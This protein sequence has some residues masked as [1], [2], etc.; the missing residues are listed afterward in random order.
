MLGLGSGADMFS[1]LDWKNGRFNRNLETT[2]IHRGLRGWQRQIGDSVVWWRFDYEESQI[3]DIYD[4]GDGVG[5]VFYGPWTIPTIHCEHIEGGNG[6]PRD[7]GL[8]QVDQLNV[9]A[10]Y[11][12]IQQ[13]GL[14]YM[15]LQTGNY[16]RDRL[17]YD[18]KLFTVQECLVLGQVVRR[19][20]IVSI[21][22][23]QIKNDELVDDPQFAQYLVDP[24]QHFNAVTL[25]GEN[26]YGEGSYGV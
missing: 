10:S 24:T 16:Q 20:I 8:Y 6:E 1:R 3:N 21:T 13:C 25:Y 7:E 23:I 2:L 18:N 4:E 11:R 22:A 26:N 19:D 14:T 17:A 9:I 5:R 12:Q 15:D